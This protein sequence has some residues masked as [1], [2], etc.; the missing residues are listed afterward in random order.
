MLPALSVAKALE[1][2]RRHSVGGLTGVR[3]MLVTTRP[4]HIPHHTTSDVGLIGSC[5]V[6]H[7]S[8]LS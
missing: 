2:I 1:T 3:T 4:F 6:K 5:L 7:V 8:R